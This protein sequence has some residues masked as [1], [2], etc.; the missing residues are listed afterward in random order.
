M[1]LQENEKNK[2]IFALGLL[3]GIDINGYKL[4]TIDVKGD[5]VIFSNGDKEEKI[6]ISEITENM[7]KGFETHD[8]DVDVEAEVIKPSA[9]V[10]KGGY[11]NFKTQSFSETSEMQFQNNSAIKYS[12][13]SDILSEMPKKLSGGSKSNIFQKSY[14]DTSSIKMSDMSKYSETSDI[15]SE[16]PKK[17]SGGSKSNIFQ[18]SYSDTSSIKMSDM[19]NYSKTSSAVFNGRSDKY[20][21]TSVIGQIG[22]NVKA[23]E[24]TSDT[25]MDVSELKS[26]KN[27]KTANLDMGIFR[28]NLSGGSIDT[29][30][31]KKMMEVGINSNSSTSSICE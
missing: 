6:I 7:P 23:N 16:M 19:S 12:E 30:M 31:R 20:S 26:R 4:S 17:L 15:L 11:N 21:D 2:I 8:V 22:G 28:K 18:K 13:T 27:A 14:S 1:N 5:T 3:M 24:I 25:L 29:N 9:E 10:I